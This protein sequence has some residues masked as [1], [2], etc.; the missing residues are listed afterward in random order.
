MKFSIIIAILLLALSVAIPTPAEAQNYTPTGSCGLGYYW[1]IHDNGWDGVLVRQGDSTTFRAFGA[2][3]MQPDGTATYNIDLQG[4]SVIMDRIDDP[5]PLGGLSCHY[6][7]TLRSGSSLVVGNNTCELTT[8]T[9]RALSWTAFII[10]QAPLVTWYDTAFWHRAAKG[11]QFNFICPPNGFPAPVWGD[12]IYI[13]G[14]SICAAGV[15]AGAI[16]LADGGLVTIEILPGEPEYP[17][18]TANGITT[19]TFPTAG[20]FDASFRVTGGQLIATPTAVASPVATSA[21]IVSWD[22]FLGTWNSSYGVV[23]IDS[24]GV[25]TYP[26]PEPTI[27]SHMYFEQ[28]DAY[29]I[30]GYWVQPGSSVNCGAERY[31]SNYWGRIRWTFDENYAKFTGVWSYCDAEPTEYWGGERPQ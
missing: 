11:Q 15:H 10:C 21:A 16:T 31:G 4:D 23:E 12:G 27:E 18:S 26:G 13:E 20:Q 24:N 14:S 8:G 2:F 1:L 30:S 3:W 9:S 7:G 25:A 19:E 28:E 22:N 5:N 6:E 29:T 17:G